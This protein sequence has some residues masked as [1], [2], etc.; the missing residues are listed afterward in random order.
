MTVFSAYANFY[1]SLYASK[2]YPAECDFLEE[3]FQ[4][5]AGNPIRTILDIGC[6]TGGHALQMARRGFKVTGVDRSGQMLSIARTKAASLKT[7]Y[8][9]VFREGDARTL[10]LATKFDAVMSM[11]AVISYLTANDDLVEAFRATRKH[12]NEGGL[13]VFDAWYGPAVLADRPTDRFKI[14]ESDGER[15][16][17]FVRPEIDLFRHVVNV[18]YKVLRI[19]NREI[20]EEVEE[21]HPMR[22]LFPQEIISYLGSAGF[23]VLRICPFLRISENI[24]ERDWNMAVVAEAKELN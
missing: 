11:F 16:F 6:G 14:M 24:G 13:F 7:D 9:P 19:K 5:H 22:F 3:I 1:D 15:I 8:S 23:R 21:M 4:Q 12:L 18:H 20:V 17:R 10:N 2:D